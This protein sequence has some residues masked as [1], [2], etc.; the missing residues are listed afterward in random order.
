MSDP[1]SR[2]DGNAIMFT[3]R[4]DRRVW[5]TLIVLIGSGILGTSL[6]LYTAWPTHIRVGYKPTQP[7]AFSH[8]LHAGSMEIAC[9]YCHTRVDSGAHATVPPLSVCMNC[10]GMFKP[11]PNKKEQAQRIGVLLDHWNRKQPVAWNKV[12]DLSDFVYFY[13][14]RHTGVGLDCRNCHGDVGTMPV[15]EQ[16]TPLTMGWCLHCHMGRQSEVQFSQ[17]ALLEGKK[18][19]PVINDPVYGRIVA[20]INCSTCHR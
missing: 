5:I 15:V 10:H 2:E 11:N 13:H 18:T 3:R 9:R 19:L 14:D 16:V 1:A 4:F 17:E 20:P 12:Y 8:E 7:I 6:T